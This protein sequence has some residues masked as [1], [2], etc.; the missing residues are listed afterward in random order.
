MKDVKVERNY[1]PGQRKHICRLYQ[2][3]LTG[4]AIANVFHTRG[5]AIYLVLR[6]EGVHINDD[7]ILPK[8]VP[9]PEDIKRKTAVIREGWSDK[10]RDHRAGSQKRVEWTPPVVTVPNMKKRVST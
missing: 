3:G 8:Y 10:E 7:H 4:A 1:T 2:R 5:S 9:S 6:E